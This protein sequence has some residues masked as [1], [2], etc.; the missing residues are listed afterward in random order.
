MCDSYF[1]VRTPAKGFYMYIYKAMYF[2]IYCIPLWIYLCSC[3]LHFPLESKSCI[4]W[5]G[6]RRLICINL[7]SLQHHMVVP[8]VS[9]W[10][11]WTSTNEKSNISLLMAY[12]MYVIVLILST[13]WPR[14]SH[15]AYQIWLYKF[16]EKEKRM[17][18]VSSKLFPNLLL[19]YIHLHDGSLCLQYSR[20]V[21]LC[22]DLTHNKGELHAFQHSFGMT[23]S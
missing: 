21:A 2:S 18:A 9:K 16:Y 11:T 19:A 3:F 23:A 6:K 22:N 17:R 10:E 15:K 4:L 8:L 1:L 14:T 13:C 5:N 7:W 20:F 12:L